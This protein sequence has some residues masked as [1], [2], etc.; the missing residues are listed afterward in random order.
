MQPSTR[1][2]LDNTFIDPWIQHIDP[3][4]NDDSF[5]VE[6]VH[7]LCG[8][9]SASEIAELKPTLCPHRKEKGIL[10]RKTT[11]FKKLYGMSFSNLRQVVM[12]T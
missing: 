11:E 5:T 6:P 2:E 7:C 4:F 8:G 10:K 3:L 1:E 9:V 12:V